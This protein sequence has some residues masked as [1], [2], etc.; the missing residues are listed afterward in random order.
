VV[1]LLLEHGAGLEI[2]DAAGW[3]ALHHASSAGADKVVTILLRAGAN[4]NTQSDFGNTPAHLAAKNSHLKTLQVLVEG[5]ADMDVI[6]THGFTPLHE[7]ARYADIDVVYF[8][9]ACG[10]KVQTLSYECDSALHRAAFSGT[11]AKDSWIVDYLTAF[12]QRSVSQG[13]VINILCRK[14]RTNALQKIFQGPKA[15]EAKLAID[16]YSDAVPPTLIETAAAGHSQVLEILLDAG[17]NIEISWRQIGTAL[18]VACARG[19]LRAVQTLVSR[20]AKL[21]CP[22][23]NGSTL[24]A[25][26]KA[27]NHPEIVKWLR[28]TRG[29][30]VRPDR[31]QFKQVF[32]ESDHSRQQRSI[33]TLRRRNSCSMIYEEWISIRL[34]NAHA[35]VP[36]RFKDT[37][38][39]QQSWTKTNVH[40]PRWARGHRLA[41]YIFRASDP[42]TSRSAPRDAWMIF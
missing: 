19:R 12:R 9:L 14:N 38:Y 33:Q 32:E 29:D 13:T 3:T 22:G 18:M 31:M 30:Q 10:G 1:S 34:S 25:A 24:D 42:R 6:D 21:S 27:K 40:E 26:E 4:P 7:A 15:D 36:Q 11:E 28:E 41:K 5:G 16:D 8:L 20:G 37:V 17:A 23:P 35:E 39:E 2:A